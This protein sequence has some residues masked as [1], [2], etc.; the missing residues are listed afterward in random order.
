MSDCSHR[1]LEYQ[2]GVEVWLT[3]RNYAGGT[4]DLPLVA[5]L[6]QHDDL[7]LSPEWYL[8]LRTGSNVE[9]G[10]LCRIVSLLPCS[11]VKSKHPAK[12]S[13][14]F[15]GILV[16]LHVVVIPYNLHLGRYTAMTSC[17]LGSM[18]KPSTPPSIPELPSHDIPKTEHR[19]H[20]AHTV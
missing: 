13:L 5:A 20:V 8:I 15:H 1:C 2:P 14:A 6:N 7:P 17:P 12:R 11:F 10:G 4:E 16:G 18:A 3:F 9:D 19:G